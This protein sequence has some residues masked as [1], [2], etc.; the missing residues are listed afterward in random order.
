MAKKPESLFLG[1]FAA[2]EIPFKFIHTFR[3][4]NGDAIN[5]TGWTPNITYTGPGALV[6][7]TGVLALDGD[8]TTG[9]VHYTWDEDDFQDVGAYE[10]LLWVEDGANRLASFLVKYEVYDGPGDTPKT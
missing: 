3:D 8:P 5:I 2:G 6:Y 1:V 4:S 9:R 7:G 10:V